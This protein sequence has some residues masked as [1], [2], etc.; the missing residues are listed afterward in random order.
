VVFFHSTRHG[1]TTFF[2]QALGQDTAEALVAAREN[3]SSLGEFCLSPDG[4]S[5][6]Y[7]PVR[8]SAQP[9]RYMQ[10]PVTG[11]AS[12]VI[13]TGDL[14]FGP[15]CSG[16]PATL[17]VVGE[18]SADRKQISFNAFDPAKGI[19]PKLAE[20][21]ALPEVGYQ[22]RLSPDGTRIA[23]YRSGETGENRIHILWVNGRAPQEI[24][25]KGWNLDDAVFWSADS[26]SLFVNSYKER[27]PVLLHVDLQGNAKVLWE[28]QGGT[29]TYAVASPDGRHLAMQK[30]T[31]D[32]N[33]W[34]MENF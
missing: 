6:L 31:V 5:L 3:E 24:T 20:F 33:L 19:G 10:V 17:C 9:D 4:L 21:A 11:G 8:S 16:S 1:K 29:A 18:R 22:S 34:M 23:V 7:G 32:G 2:R 15:Q 13:Y 27:V 28:V 14:Y 12:Q 30:M 26:K 25:L